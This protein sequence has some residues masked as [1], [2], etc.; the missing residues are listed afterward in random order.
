MSVGGDNVDIVNGVKVVDVFDKMRANG[1]EGLV[2]GGKRN[3]I[4]EVVTGC[5]AGPRESFGL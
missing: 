1:G 3:F 5:V 2:S 4:G